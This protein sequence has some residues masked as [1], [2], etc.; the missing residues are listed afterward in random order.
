MIVEGG[1][2]KPSHRR[3][4]GGGRTSA[5]EGTGRT[6]EIR[7]HRRHRLVGERQAHAVAGRGRC[8]RDGAWSGQ[9]RRDLPTARGRRQVRARTRSHAGF[10]AHDQHQPWSARSTCQRLAA[11]VDDEE[12]RRT[13]AASRRDRQQHRVGRGLRR[14]GRAGR[15][16]RVESRRGGNDAAARARPLAARH[17]RDDHRASEFSRRR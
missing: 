2:S 10:S 9:L 15:L 3:P 12:L 8:L 6:R 7:P 14:P 1:G 17:P 5:R 16:R 4:Q 13:P 11:E